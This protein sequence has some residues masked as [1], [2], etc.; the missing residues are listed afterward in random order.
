MIAGLAGRNDIVP[1]VESA[2]RAW[3]NVVDSQVG[4]LALAV[5]AGE[6]IANEDFAPSQ[7]HARSWPANHVHEADDGGGREDGRDAGQTMIACFEDFGT[8]AND[9]NKCAPD[10]A[11]VQ[12]LV[13]L[14]E[15][16]DGVV[17]PDEFLRVR[18]AADSL[19]TR[20]RLQPGD[21]ITAR[22]LSRHNWSNNVANFV[23][24][25]IELTDSD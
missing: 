2:T 14:I 7:L 23:R 12:R 9:K 10:I 13:V 17:H 19:R 24:F 18:I 1:D 3:D 6:S 21:A 16:E 8:A 5:L 15:H 22:I 20:R 11:H 25:P 4:C